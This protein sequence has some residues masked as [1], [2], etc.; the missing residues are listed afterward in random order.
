MNLNAIISN[1]RN[2]NIVP[3]KKSVTSYYKGVAESKIA[4]IKYENH[5]LK[6]AINI[7]IDYART[8]RVPNAESKFTDRVKEIGKNLWEWILKQIE[9]V[10]AFFSK[11]FG[12]NNNFSKRGEKINQMVLSLRRKVNKLAE[13]YDDND[14]FTFNVYYTQF[15]MVLMSRENG[16]DFSKVYTAVNYSLEEKIGMMTAIIKADEDGQHISET[17][18]LQMKKILHSARAAQYMPAAKPIHKLLEHMKKKADMKNVSDYV[19]KTADGHKMTLKQIY[20]ELENMNRYMNTNIFA[21]IPT[22]S[23]SKDLEF[24][25]RWARKKSAE[26]KVTKAN[27]ED[28]KRDKEFVLYLNEYIYRFEMLTKDY[29]KLI[30]Q[31]YKFNEKILVT[32]NR[33]IDAHLKTN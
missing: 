1:V 28:S 19:D 27:D 25:S 32:Y 5:N 21:A 10:K 18:L 14:E 11:I 2:N 20:E 24:Y 3:V 17:T 15:V 33:L 31:I 8:G 26:L 12:G 22:S 9:K 23:V 6:E 13:K 29:F 30:D 7:S 16:L 4:S